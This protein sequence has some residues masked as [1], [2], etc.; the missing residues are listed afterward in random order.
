MFFFAILRSISFFVICTRASVRL[1]N[2]IFS[3]LLRTPVAFFDSNP[4]GRI[5]NRF[6][7][8]TGCLDEKIPYVAHDFT[9]ILS[10][11]VGVIVTLAI[12]NW[13]L[14]FPAA[15]LVSLIVLLRQLYLKAARDIKR[16]EAMSKFGRDN[17][18]KNC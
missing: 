9:L 3:R 14:L 13:L 5:L 16:Y 4:A 10:Q 1:H 7:A 6:S 18:N 17:I 11:A 15:L 2:G 12:A 8:D